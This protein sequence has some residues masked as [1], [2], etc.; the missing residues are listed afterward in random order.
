MLKRLFDIIVA[1]LLL[2]VCSP[3]LA[4]CALLV[5]LTSPGPVVFKSRRIG[6]AGVI[7]SM[8][9]FRTMREGTPQLATHLVLNPSEFLTPVGR[10]LR[11]SSLDELP[12]LWNVLWGEMSLVGPRPALFNQND[13]IAL[14]RESGVEIL[15]PGV[16]GWAQVKGRDTLSIEEKAALDKHYLHNRSFLFD[17]EILILTAFK[18]LKAEGIRH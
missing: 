4:G 12:Q 8:W 14:R 18:V 3:V 17:L 11:R 13:L 7:F 15:R 10:F 9:K 2:L 16:T 1:A 5:R 6:R